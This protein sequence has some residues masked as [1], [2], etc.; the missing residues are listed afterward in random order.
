MEKGDSGE[1]DTSLPVLK[2]ELHDEK[3]L[4]YLQKKNVEKKMN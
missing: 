3:S 4:S 2:G 1:K